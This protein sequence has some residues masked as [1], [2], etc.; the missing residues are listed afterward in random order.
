MMI[1]AVR[2][3]GWAAILVAAT[4]SLA[5][6]QPTLSVD[7]TE[8]LLIT[9][10]G[11]TLRSIEL[12]GATL[13]IGS[14]G[15]EIE[16][17]I[18]G[19]ADDP[20]AV[21]GRVMLHH[22]VVKDGSGRKVDLC[23]PDAEGRSLGFPI[24]DGHGSFELTCTSGA[25]GKC[26]RWGYRPWEEMPGGPPMR[27]LHQACIHM[28]RADYGGDGRATTRDGTMIE[29]Y[30]RFGIQRSDREVPMSFEAG[31][32]VGG[33]TCV[34]RPRI[35]EN[36]SLEQLGER[37]P[38][39]KSRLGEKACTEEGAMRDPRALLFNRSRQ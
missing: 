36:I 14:A 32:G 9:A 39:L 25:V 13:R 30:D 28:A 21:G 18:A 37:Y 16:I 17:T 19:V 20:R 26:V 15:T 10:D 12:E 27:A 4:A 29:M 34:A 2:R 3:L 33:A 35:P 24:P 38:H 22:F 31:W 23:A 1:S 8:F 11:R 5:S 6:A 7:G